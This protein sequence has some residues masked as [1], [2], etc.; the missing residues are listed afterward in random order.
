[1][2]RI[3]DTEIIDF[4]ILDERVLC[5]RKTKNPMIPNKKSN[6]NRPPNAAPII[7][8]VEKREDDTALVE[9]PKVALK[10]DINI[11]YSPRKGTYDAATAVSA[12]TEVPLGTDKDRMLEVAMLSFGEEL[13]VVLPMLSLGGGFTMEGV[14][15]L[16]EGV[17]VK[18]V[19]ISKSTKGPAD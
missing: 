17:T 4:S 6:V 5:L 2:G 12:A 7:V 18:T 9:E 16:F 1:M 15:L 10:P 11:G 8:P 13:T 14:V 3:G 19:I